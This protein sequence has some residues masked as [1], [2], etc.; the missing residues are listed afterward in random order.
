M[1]NI[2]S[3][4]ELEFFS[5]DEIEA[6]PLEQLGAVYGDAKATAAKVAKEKARLTAIICRR[7]SDELENFTT[8]TTTI[9]RGDVELKVSAPKRVDWDQAA[10]AK[11]EKTIR[12]DWKSS[13]EEY[14]TIKR[15]VSESAYNGWPSALQAPFEDAR[16]V[17]AGSKT[18]EFRDLKNRG[19]E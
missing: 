13:P 15:S 16:T 8:G 2:P 18:L 14:M 17:K 9:V 3:I 5:D 11:L 6:M 19:G 7:F 10:L 1:H 12:E 4:L